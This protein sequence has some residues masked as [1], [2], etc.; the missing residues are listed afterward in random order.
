MHTANVLS[1]NEPSVV[2]EFRVQVMEYINAYNSGDEER[3]NACYAP[4][5]WAWAFFLRQTSS[6]FQRV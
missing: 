6:L 2:E 5:A 3:L 1:E 4:D